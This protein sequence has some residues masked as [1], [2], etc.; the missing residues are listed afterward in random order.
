[1]ATIVNATDIHIDVQ[2]T[3]KFNQTAILNSTMFNGKLTTKPIPVS[4]KA[5]FH[6]LLFL[7]FIPHR[8]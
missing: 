3:D 8:K 5:S 1:M 7:K 6:A 2:S 4:R